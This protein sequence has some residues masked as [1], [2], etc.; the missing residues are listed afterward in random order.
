LGFP[1]KFIVVLGARNANEL[2]IREFV[3]IHYERD[4]LSQKANHPR[5][6]YTATLYYCDLD[7]DP[8]TLIYEPDLEIPHLYLHTENERLT[9]RWSTNSKLSWNSTHGQVFLLLWPW[10]WPD[11]TLIYEPDL[12]NLKMY[13]TSKNEISM[14]ML[15]NVR[16]LQTDRQTHTDRRDRTHH[17]ATFTVGKNIPRPSCRPLLTAGAVYAPEWHMQSVSR[18]HSQEKLHTRQRHCYIPESVWTESQQKIK[19]QYLKRTQFSNIMTPWT[20]A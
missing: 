6:W 7:L 20:V 18:F 16:A 11:M 3:R 10:P 14:L 4:C 2:N 15:S 9:F 19:C 12:K 17:H 13:R 1:P 5:T 8:M